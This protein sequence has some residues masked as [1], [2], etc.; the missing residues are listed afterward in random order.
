VQYRYSRTGV[1]LRSDP[2]KRTQLAAAVAKPAGCLHHSLVRPV[3]YSLPPE[4]TFQRHP[5]QG[6][7]GVTTQAGARRHAVF[8][9]PCPWSLQSHSY[10]SASKMLSTDGWWPWCFV[11]CGGLAGEATRQRTRTFPFVTS[12]D[13]RTRLS[14]SGFSCRETKAM[15]LVL[16]TPRPAKYSWY[17]AHCKGKCG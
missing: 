4:A 8:H 12:G 14:C 6:Q 7:G 1:Q 16:P 5:R 10:L 2:G 17:L 15:C 3:L 9:T 11:R 13:S